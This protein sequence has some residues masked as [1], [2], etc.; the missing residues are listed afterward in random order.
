[1]SDSVV[2]NRNKTASAVWNTEHYLTLKTVPNGLATI[3]GENWYTQGTNRVLTAPQ[4]AGHAFTY[5]DFDGVSQG[6]GT[7]PVTI[8]MNNPHTASAHYVKAYSLA[9][10]AGEGGAT[11]PST[12]T[13]LYPEGS[14]IQVT[15][16]P[17]PN[18][19]LDHWEL[20]GIDSGSLNPYVVTMN[21]NHTLSATFRTAPP[22]SASIDPINMSLH[23]GEPG[24]FHS[25]VAGGIPPYSRQWYLDGNPVSGA[26]SDSW[27]FT[28]VEVGIH[29]VCLKVTD[30]DSNIAQSET[31]RIEVSPVPVGGYTFSPEKRPIVN[32]LT[33]NIALAVSLALFLVLARRKTREGL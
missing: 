22:L 28:P 11:S 26:I 21:G 7:N 32:P 15:A 30:H 27:V 29:Y 1:M 16:N 4:V 17:S 10:A 20:D 8:I 12:G 9:I 23:V 19:E 33:L 5:W 6:N 2:M 3:P 13:H 31:A 18:F 25:T 24:T 14:M